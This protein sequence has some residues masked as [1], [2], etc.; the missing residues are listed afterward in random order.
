MRQFS[1]WLIE[2]RR[3]EEPDKMIT[4]SDGAG[5]PE[6]DVLLLE[7]RGRVL[8]LTMNRPAQRNALNLE[9]RSALRAA[10]DAFELDD[11]LRCAVLTGNGP[12]FCAGGDLKEMADTNMRVPP[13][14]SFLLLGSTGRLTK[15]V[16]AAVNGHARAGGFLLMQD[17]DL[18][19]AA[20][21]ATFAISEVKRGR[22][23]PWAVP[24]AN[25]VT[26]RVMMELLLTG[27][28]FDAR[29]AFEVG[30]VNRVVP[31]AELLDT[32]IAMAETIAGNAPLSVWAAKQLV[33][34]ACEMGESAATRAAHLIYNR[35]YLSDDAAEGPRA[36]A[37]KRQPVWTGH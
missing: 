15:P 10:F 5:F 4:K 19:I 25:I 18:A 12:A 35:V 7:R 33:E 37:E 11:A 34:L 9:L 14:N 17:C 29:R 2:Q 36:F 31:A 23:A 28:P 24:L 32:A 26:K 13:E 6:T 3:A 8:V 27:D 20:E 30:L 1:S 21:G 22:G 16:I